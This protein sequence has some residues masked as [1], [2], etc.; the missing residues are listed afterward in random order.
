MKTE[1]QAQDDLTHNEVLDMWN[2]LHDRAVIAIL[3]W[4][5]FYKNNKYFPDVDVRCWPTGDDIASQND[6]GRRQTATYNS[7]LRQLVRWGVVESREKPSCVKGAVVYRVVPERLA[8]LFWFFSYKEIH[9]KKL[10]DKEQVP[11]QVM[12]HTPLF[13]RSYTVHLVGREGLKRYTTAR[14]RT[15]LF[16]TFF[17]MT[18]V[19]ALS[20]DEDYQQLSESQKSFIDTQ[21]TSLRTNLSKATEALGLQK[22]AAAVDKEDEIIIKYGNRFTNQLFLLDPLNGRNISE[23]KARIE[24]MYSYLLTSKNKKEI[25]I[26]W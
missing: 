6:Q 14:H 21:R 11:A 26:Q 10:K 25:L 3:S 15:I 22:Y 23:Y 1:S 13:I 2:V 16:K 7:R 12:E 18:L 5:A 19:A 9:G 8:E 4:N 24:R 17:V 20:S